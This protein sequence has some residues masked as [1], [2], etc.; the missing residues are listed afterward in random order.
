MAVAR[1]PQSLWILSCRLSSGT[2]VHAQGPV[3]LLRDFF[4][5]GIPEQ[6]W[7][8]HRVNMRPG[9]TQS[10]LVAMGLERWL[11][12]KARRLCEL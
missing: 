9:R 8:S 6:A 2:R 4:G 10:D 1:N 12:Q 11:E 7:S 3:M 5:Q